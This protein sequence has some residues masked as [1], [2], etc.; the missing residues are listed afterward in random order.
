MYEI[1]LHTYFDTY[2]PCIFARSWKP[3]IQGVSLSI[4]TTNFHL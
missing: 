3:Y 4:E 1:G 2:I